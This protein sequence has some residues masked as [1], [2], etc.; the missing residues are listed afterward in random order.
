MLSIVWRAL[1]GYWVESYKR[2]AERNKIMPNKRFRT[3]TLFDQF[4]NLVVAESLRHG[5]V[6]PA[7]FASLNLSLYTPDEAINVIENRRLFYNGLG[8]EEKQVIGSYQVH[9]DEVLVTKNAGQYKGYDA[10]ISDKA[11]LCISISVAD[12]TPVVIYDAQKKI[13]AGAHAGWRGTVSQIAKKTLNA[14]IAT[15]NTNPNDC[16]AY[17]GTCIDADSYEVDNDVAMHFD[18]PFKRWDTQKN[19]F[20]IDLKKANST[21]LESSGIP[22]DQIAIS[23][24]ST[25]QNNEDYFSHRKEKGRTGR[26]MVVIGLL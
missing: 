25:Y 3:P 17:I 5:G 23:P 16:F 12:C 9:K 7:P 6:S 26:A 1:R 14:M 4:E 8:F 10:I 21:Q 15:Y 18:N 13:I 2:K 24:Y 22:S 19:K 11:G 20:F